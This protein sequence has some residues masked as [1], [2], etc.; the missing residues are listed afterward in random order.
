M[1]SELIPLMFLLCGAGFMFVAALGVVRFPD[2]YTRMHAV[3]KSGSLALGC[4][5][6]AVAI[7]HPTPT[8]IGK[9]FLVLLFI[10]LTTPIAAHMIGRAAFLL[11]VPFWR[12]TVSNELKDRYSDDRTNLSSGLPSIS[13]PPLAPGNG[14]EGD[15][16][17]PRA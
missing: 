9:C 13:G 3:S 7:Q 4:I 14:P 8:V 5:L 11:K 12:G 10:F 1:K 15:T 17:R 16:T 2:L 6:L